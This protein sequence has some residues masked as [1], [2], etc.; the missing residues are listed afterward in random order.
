MQIQTLLP[1]PSLIQL[2]YLVA[3]DAMI[4][5]VA[6][7]SQREATCP[8][9]NRSC[10]SALSLPPRRSLSPRHSTL[11]RAGAADRFTEE[12][13]KGLLPRRQSQ[14][15]NVRSGVLLMRYGLWRVV[16]SD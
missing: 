12:P 15:H 6:R 5:L 16:P 13:R 9:C 11:L 1:A 8:N 4:T 10:I 2:D 14:L 3:S 7:T